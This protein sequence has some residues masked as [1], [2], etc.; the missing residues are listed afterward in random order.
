M[1]QQPKL[2]VVGVDGSPASRAALDFALQEGL[3]RGATVEVVSAWVLS[4]PYEGLDHA[5]TFEE[6]R[7]TAA[8]TQDRVVA[9]ATEGLT[10][11][12]VI[13]QEVVH[14][15]AGKTLVERSDG[16]AMIVVGSGRKGAVTRAILGSVSEYVVR[17]AA[18]PVVVVPD[19]E[20]VVHHDP[21]SLE[22]STAGS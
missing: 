18:C 13:S 7:D 10:T 17:H 6:G 2:I 8:T 20:R 3:A 9:A 14:D 12:P 16:A 15:Y 11:L 5:T 22:S 19:P 4:S 21:A 1:T